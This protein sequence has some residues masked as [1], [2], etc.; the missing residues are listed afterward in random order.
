MA[1]EQFVAAAKEHNSDIISC[2][3]LLTTT[4]GEMKNVVDLVKANSE[5]SGRVKVMIGGA[6]VT[7]AFCRK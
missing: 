5:L 4:M 2:S 7:E 6:P 3:A 1:P